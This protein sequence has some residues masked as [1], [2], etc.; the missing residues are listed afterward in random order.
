MR[1]RRFNYREEQYNRTEETRGLPI[2][3]SPNTV[4]PDGQ[5][6]L[7]FSKIHAMENM[8]LVKAQTAETIV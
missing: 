3:S 8:C 4:R 1:C 6:K 5:A 2:A 7:R